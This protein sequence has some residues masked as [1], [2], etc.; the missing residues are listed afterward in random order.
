MTKYKY[1]NDVLIITKYEN[2]TFIYNVNKK[3]TIIEKS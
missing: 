3:I 1:G 2:F